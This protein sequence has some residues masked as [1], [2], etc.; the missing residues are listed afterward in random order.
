MK[1]TEKIDKYLDGEMTKQEATAFEQQVKTNPDLAY[2]VKLH[3]L[4]VAGIQHSEEARFQEFK[5][6]MKAIESEVKDETPIVQ[7]QLRLTSCFDLSPT[8]LH[9]THKKSHK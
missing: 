2:E 4:A 8:Q 5:S 1:Y 7:L 6:R 3:Q 9:N